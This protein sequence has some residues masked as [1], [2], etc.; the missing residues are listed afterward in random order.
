M[1]Y[2]DD[3]LSADLFTWSHEPVTQS[4][5]PDEAGQ[6]RANQSMKQVHKMRDYELDQLLP[7]LPTCLVGS[8]GVFTSERLF[9]SCVQ[10]RCVPH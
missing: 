7:Y 1:Y 9:Y 5:L 8:G 2:R 4:E 10:G 6:D 3:T